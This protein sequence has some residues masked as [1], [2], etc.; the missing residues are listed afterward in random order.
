MINPIILPLDKVR[1]PRDLGSYVGYNGRKIK[2][3]RLLRTGKISNITE[4][5]KKFL[6]DYGLTKIIDLRSPF[7][8]K[9]APDSQIPG[10]EHIDLSISTEDNTKGGKKDITKVFETYRKD[11]YAGFNMMCDRYRSHVMKEHAQHALH[12][13]LEVLANTKDGAI[14]YHCSEGKDR[15]CIVTVLIL[16]LLGV[17]METIRQDYLYSNYML[18]NYRASRDK[19]MQEN[20]ENLCFRANMRILGS[21]SDAFLDTSLIA[22]HKNFGSLDNYLKEIIGVT[23]ELRDTLR[24]L[25]LED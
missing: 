24:E 15:T 6:L 3:H 5:D 7:E 16:Y 23:P 10:V 25:Y 21:V 13:I 2:M 1:N 22:I 18:D 19:I 17:D 4:H 9:K 20:G 14:I 12:S 8:C 11:Q